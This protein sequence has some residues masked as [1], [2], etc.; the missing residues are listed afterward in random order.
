MKALTHSQ[1]SLLLL[2]ISG[3]FESPGIGVEGKLRNGR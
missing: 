1:G 2:T 3:D